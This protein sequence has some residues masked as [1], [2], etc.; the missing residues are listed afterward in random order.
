MKTLLV[1][2]VIALAFMPAS[3]AQDSDAGAI[4]HFDEYL[5]ACPKDEIRCVWFLNGNVRI[6]MV[7]QLNM[8]THETTTVR[9]VHNW[10]HQSHETRK[11]SHPQIETLKTLA[12]E[13]P[14]SASA[15]SRVDLVYIAYFANDSVA[16]KKYLRRELPREVQ[17][18][19]DI[20]GGYI[21]TSHKK[22][23]EDK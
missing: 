5:A 19:Y 6:G 9:E 15:N 18:F 8:S 16:I 21:D 22:K 2:S 7:M 23:S 10:A 3:H 14:D 12:D 13:M 4:K 1:I 11:L 17:R 20:G